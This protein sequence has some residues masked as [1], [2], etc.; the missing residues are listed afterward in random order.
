LSS[1]QTSYRSI[2]K[3]TSIFGGV[4]VFNILVTLIRGKATAVLIGTTGMGLNGFLL[5]GLKLISSLTSLGISSSA[6]RD[7]SIAYGES[8]DNRFETTYTVFRNWIWFTA[9]LGV[10]SSIL[11]A[12]LLS[13]FAFG[14]NSY[15][16]AYVWL[17]TTFI[18]GALSG[19]IYTVLRAVRKVNYLAQANIYG[20]VGG[21]LVTLPILYYWRIDG[22]MPSIIAASAVTYFISIYF[23]KKVNIKVLN[24][25]LKETF[26][27]GKPM[28]VMGINMSLSSVLA[29]VSVFILSA[30]ITNQGSLSDLGLYS[31]GMSIMGGYI[32]MVFTA[33]GTD[34]FPRLSAVIND[35][36]K[37]KEVVHHQAELVLILL[38][39][40]LVL[41]VVTS[42]ILIRILLSREFLDT[43]D[44]I[45]ISAL[46]IPLKGLVWVLG[47]VILSKGDNRLFFITELL[48]NTWFLGFNLLF[49]FF[50]SIEGIA[51]SMVLNYLLS[52]F[53]MLFIMKKYYNYHIKRSVYLLLI[54][55]IISILALVLSYIYIEGTLQIGLLVLISLL[56]LVYQFY[57]LNKRLNI[58]EI[59]MSKFLKKE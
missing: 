8:D 15:T 30:F 40:V 25:N 6:V 32:G 9:I 44:F 7:L 34:Y 21:L 53:M 2:F 52:I 37:W 50:Y 1:K 26:N 56:A 35:E 47:F 55:G 24:L 16:S 18:F 19:G 27:L 43:R 49:Y 10:L 39:I 23:R 29:S 12:P 57:E 33:I 36:I 31:A 42:P 13:Q 46:S 59:L 22:V 48:S 38:T 51:I 17:S 54:V 14:N 3:A 58:K 4:Q 5:S 20:S 45:I 41:L 11:F 28:V